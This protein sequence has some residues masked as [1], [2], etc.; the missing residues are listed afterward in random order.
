MSQLC[1]CFVR[2]QFAFC[3]TSKWGRGRCIWVTMARFGLW[4]PDSVWG[5][6]VQTNV[7][8]HYI[9]IYIYIYTVLWYY[10]WLYSTSAM[11]VYIMTCCQV[12][13]LLLGRSSHTG[14]NVTPLFLMHLGF[15]KKMPVFFGNPWRECI[16]AYYGL[17]F[18]RKERERERGE[19]NTHCISLYIQR[20]CESYQ[21]NQ[22]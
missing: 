5:K 4:L 17:G 8:Y 18:C 13:K 9:S 22:D 20:C 1:C 2:G 14:S 19:E 3:W 11:G 15:W 10:K 21:N 16:M 12:V 6:D 7:I